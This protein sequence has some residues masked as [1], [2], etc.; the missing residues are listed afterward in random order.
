MV[1]SEIWSRIKSKLEEYFETVEEYIGFRL[2][3]LYKYKDEF[4]F[5]RR[6]TDN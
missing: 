1:R 2:Y 4:I 3:N 6:Y 5:I